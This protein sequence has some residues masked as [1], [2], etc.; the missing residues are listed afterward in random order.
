MV[1]KLCS[2]SHGQPEP[3]VRSAAMMS[4]STEMSRE[5]FMPASYQTGQ[6]GATAGAGRTQKSEKASCVDCLVRTGRGGLCARH[7][8]FASPDISQYAMDSIAMDEF[9]HLSHAHPGMRVQRGGVVAADEQDAFAA[10]QLTP[11][12]REQSAGQAT[13]ALAP[14]DA[15]RP[16]DIGVIGTRIGAPH[17]L[18]DRN[19]SVRRKR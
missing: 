9:G 2:R 6:A 17:D 15:D 13:A 5:G 1:A 10:R 4:I 14:G 8:R 12:R 11:K 3:G 7:D 16:I 18:H 19:I